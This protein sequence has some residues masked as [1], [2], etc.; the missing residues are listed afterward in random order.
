MQIKCLS[1]ALEATY[2]H[3][4]IAPFTPPTDAFLNTHDLVV[5]VEY[6][7]DLVLY[8]ASLHFLMLRRRSVVSCPK[9]FQVK[10][11][12]MRRRLIS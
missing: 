8:P 3:I 10:Y 7:R 5:S 4:V 1:H 6:L 12:G 11:L 9:N 2:I